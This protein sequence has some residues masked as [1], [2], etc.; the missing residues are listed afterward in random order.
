MKTDIT[1]RAMTPDDWKEVA[2]IYREGIETGNATFQLEVPAWSEW[3][4]AH[5]P[6]CRIVAE[7]GLHVVGWAALTPVSG[8][9]VYAGVAEVSVY[10]AA[11]HQGKKIGA[12][13]LERLIKASEQ[14]NYWTLQAGI[15]PENLAS[16]KLHEAAG[17]RHVGLREKIGKM[18]GVW[19]DTLLL[20][21][22]SKLVGLK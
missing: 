21:R 20:E 3:D 7:W 17:F 13:L 22:R 9:C 1:F 4:A 10:V 5:L 18:R 2:E 19:R 14:H 6:H 12:R 16:V 8:R 15:F 11:Q